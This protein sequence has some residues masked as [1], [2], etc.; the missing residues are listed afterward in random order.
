MIFKIPL[1]RIASGYRIWPEYRLH[2]IFF[3]LRSLSMMLLIWL[4]RSL[5][6]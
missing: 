6:V 3:A 5:H 4:S 2:S 1:K